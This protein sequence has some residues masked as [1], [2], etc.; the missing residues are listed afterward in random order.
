MNAYTYLGRRVRSERLIFTCALIAL[1]CVGCSQRAGSRGSPRD[2]GA[3]DSAT[4]LDGSFDVD[5]GLRAD[6]AT[7]V[8]MG[9]R[10][11]IPSTP[12]EVDVVITADNAYSFGYGTETAITT[13]YPGTRATSAGQ[14]FSCP[15]GE[16]P[17][18]YIVPADD[19]P[20]G[21]YLYIVSWD[22]HSVTQGVIAQFKRIDAVLYSG[23]PAFE[24]CATGVDF[25]TAGGPT[26]EQ[27]NAE[28]GRCNA[29]SG[30]PATTSAG[31]VNSAGA[32]SDTPGAVGTLAVGEAND[33][34]VTG[35]PYG[36]FPP[37][38]TEDADGAKGIEPGAHWMWY[39]PMDG[40]ATRG[41]F[42]STGSN[43]FRA[44]LIFRVP[45]DSIILL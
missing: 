12:S 23:D 39:D 31:W 9:G 29:A 45:A 22:D 28:I 35:V 20:P 5:A 2:G 19:A 25:R 26:E 38:C 44:F 11:P 34:I 4:S 7:S 16:G 10:G 1:A 43:S 21:A 15:I 36:A 24:V 27:V 13:Y 18:H 8:D 6:G 3:V 42:Y 41:A 40:S 37:V 33:P 17:E 32:I 30:D 14:I